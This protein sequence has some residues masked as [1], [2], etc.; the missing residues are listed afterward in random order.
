MTQLDNT[1]TSLSSF[2]RVVSSIPGITQSDGSNPRTD[3]ETDQHYHLS[4]ELKRLGVLRVDMFYGR[5]RRSFPKGVPTVLY[6]LRFVNLVTDR[7]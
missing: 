5:P 7:V 2:R 3:T 6:C 4:N 1:Q